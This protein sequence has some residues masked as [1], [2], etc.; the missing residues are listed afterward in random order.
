MERIKSILVKE[1]VNG[2]STFDRFFMIAML[3]VQIVVYF[4]APD[5][6]IGIIAGISGVICCFVCKRKNF[7]LL[8]WLCTNNYLSDFGLAKL[9][10]W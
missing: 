3:L 10:L 2:Y 5:S 9:F 1:F 7:I 6:L 8:Y 4:I